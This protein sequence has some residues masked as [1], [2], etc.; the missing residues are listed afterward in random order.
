MINYTFNL[1]HLS[2]IGLGL[3]GS[4]LGLEVILC[5]GKTQFPAWHLNYPGSCDFTF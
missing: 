2:F 1:K 5:I 4:D 3:Y